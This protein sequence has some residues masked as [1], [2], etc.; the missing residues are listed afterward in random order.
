MK[1][2][3][4]FFVFLIMGCGR[5]VLAPCGLGGEGCSC[6]PNGDCDPGLVCVADTCENKSHGGPGQGGGHVGSGGQVGSGGRSGSG[7]WM[8]TSVSAGSGGRTN[9]GG[10]TIDWTSDDGRTNMGGWMGTAGWMGTG[11]RTS[12]GGWTSIGGWPGVG[13]ITSM[14]GVL[15]RA[16]A[17]V[18]FRDGQAQDP[19]IDGRAWV[20]LGAKDTLIS[21]TCGGAPIT[22]ASPCSSTIKWSGTGLCISGTIPALPASPSKA[23]RDENWGI[24]IGINATEEPGGTLNTRFRNTSF[25]VVGAPS[26]GAWAVFHRKGDPSSVKYCAKLGEGY[27]YFGNRTPLN[28][29]TTNCRE[30]SGTQL[31][32]D[33][34]PNI[35]WIGV[36]IPSTNVDLN[37]AMCWTTVSFD[38]W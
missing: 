7:G 2:T 36:E 16:T 37:V 38:N 34:V 22:S 15:S 26:S 5:T 32:P 29:F 31:T 28:T 11:G 13:G 4:V 35:D 14:G 9:S 25:V 20:S 17:Y 18:T 6:H 30:S 3:Y 12:T 21:P 10:T 8:S 19:S 27:D 24:M 33:D 1:P 23:D